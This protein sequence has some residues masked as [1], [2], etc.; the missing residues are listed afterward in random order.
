MKIWTGLTQAQKGVDVMA[1]LFDYCNKVVQFP[2][3]MFLFCFIFFAN[4]I[5]VLSFQRNLKLKRKTHNKMLFILMNVL[6]I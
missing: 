2:F 6:A 1:K 4:F 3:V 5:W